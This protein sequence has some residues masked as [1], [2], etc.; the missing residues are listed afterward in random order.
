MLAALLEIED[1]SPGARRCLGRFRRPGCSHPHPGREIGYVLFS[2]LT[3]RW[4]A[5]E[6]I[7]IA[8]RPDEE[9]LGRLP[10]YDGG[11]AVASLEEAGAAFNGQVGLLVSVSS[12]ALQA[13]G[14]QHG[15]DLLL[16]ELDSGRIR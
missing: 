15:A 12:V 2:E 7:P 3:R 11:A 10:W 5:Q 6:V 4:H 16:K 13:I 14:R 1:V 9:T 8:D